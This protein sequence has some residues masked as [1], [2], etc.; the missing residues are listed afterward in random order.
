MTH[1][2]LLVRSMMVS[3]TFN[4]SLY[5]T[6]VHSPPSAVSD[7]QRINQPIEAMKQSRQAE[8]KSKKDLLKREVRGPK[9]SYIDRRSF[10][11]RKGGKE[12][13]AS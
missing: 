8:A 13:S 4:T 9:P 10:S 11:A 3:I 1:F 5:R 12:D 7:L 2:L 6:T